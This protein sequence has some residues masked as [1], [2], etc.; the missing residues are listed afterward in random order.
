MRQGDNVPDGALSR[1]HAA[2]NHADNTNVINPL[3][4][5]P[6]EAIQKLANMT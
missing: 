4:K 3:L 5:F 6:N 1:H 2:L